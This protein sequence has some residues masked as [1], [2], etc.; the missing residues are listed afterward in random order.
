VKQL[1]IIATP[2]MLQRI[3]ESEAATKS[4]QAK[5]RKS[6][7]SSTSQPEIP[8]PAANHE[9]LGSSSDEDILDCMVVA[10]V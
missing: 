5:R 1:T 8:Q 2:E 6:S 9:S 10:S 4:R 3:E 7:H